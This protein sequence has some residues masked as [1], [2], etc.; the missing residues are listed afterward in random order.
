MKE[1]RYAKQ[2]NF[3]ECL[4]GL[5]PISVGE[6]CREGVLFCSEKSA[7]EIANESAKFATTSDAANLKIMLVSASAHGSIGRAADS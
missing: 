5:Q 4:L 6:F 3:Y 2:S 7:N 1:I